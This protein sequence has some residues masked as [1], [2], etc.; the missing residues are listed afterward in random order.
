MQLILLRH[1]HK[2]I[3][4]AADPELSAPGFKQAEKLTEAI[5]QKKLPAPDK[6]WVSEKIRTRQTIEAASQKFNC[7]IETSD[8]INLRSYSETASDFRLRIKKM[9]GLL[10]SLANDGSKQTHYLCTHYDWIEDAL[11]F[12]PST[13][14]LTSFEF[15]S[16]SPAQYI[17]FE[18]KDSTWTVKAKGAIPV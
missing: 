15:S 17:H 5:E 3:T 13:T 2:G 10:N 12:I 1:A 14:D 9:I 6:F 8:L 11:V 4:P 7:T 16:W 18:I